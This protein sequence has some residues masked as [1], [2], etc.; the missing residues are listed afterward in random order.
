MALQQRARWWRRYRARRPLAIRTERSVRAN[1]ATADRRAQRK[2][3]SAGAGEMTA[4]AATAVA[5]PTMGVTSAGR[6]RCHDDVADLV[7]IG[8]CPAHQVL[9]VARTTNAAAGR[10]NRSYRFARRL[11]TLQRDLVRGSWRRDR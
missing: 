10:D 6:T 4:T 5:T 1:A 8:S 2:N 7:D 11:S 9:R 3:E